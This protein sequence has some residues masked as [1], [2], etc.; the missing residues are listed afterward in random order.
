MWLKVGLFILNIHF[1]SNQS[2]M[3][4]KGKTKYLFLSGLRVN[5]PHN[6]RVTQ[7]IVN[8]L[9]HHGEF[10]KTTVQSKYPFTPTKHV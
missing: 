6:I 7:L 5:S 1:Q 4:V 3:S 10:P 2:I 8:E 9:C